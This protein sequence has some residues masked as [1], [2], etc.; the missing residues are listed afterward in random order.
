MLSIV[1]QIVM[2]VSFIALM[3]LI[4]RVSKRP[5]WRVRAVVYGWGLS[6]VWALLWALLVPM[7][8]RGVMD[9]HTLAATFPDGALVMGFLVGGWFWPMIVVAVGSYQERKNTGDDH[10]A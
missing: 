5:R 4:W 7:S 1:F 3:V 8:L 9:S 6:I 2:F 10:V